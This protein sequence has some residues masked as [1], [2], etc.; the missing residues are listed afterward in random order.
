MKKL[1]PNQKILREGSV[2]EVKVECEKVFK[3]FSKTM[4]SNPKAASYM[5]GNL[6][7]FLLKKKGEE[8]KLVEQCI[9]QTKEKLNKK[10][11]TDLWSGIERLTPEDWKTLPAGNKNSLEALRQ[12]MLQDIH[13]FQNID[14]QSL[15]RTG[16]EFRFTREV[17][18]ALIRKDLLNNKRS[19]PFKMD[20]FD[21]VLLRTGGAEENHTYLYSFINKINVLLINDVVSL[22]SKNEKI[23]EIILKD[24]STTAHYFSVSE[25]LAEFHPKLRKEI[26]ENWKKQIATHPISSD[27]KDPLKQ[28]LDRLKAKYPEF[29]EVEPKGR[30]P[31]IQPRGADDEP[32]PAWQNIAG[33]ATVGGIL[34]F[35]LKATV[36]VCT[37]PALLPLYF[38]AGGA[39]LGLACSMSES[40]NQAEKKM[41][42]KV[43]SV[44][45]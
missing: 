38:I 25:K 41:I 33:G 6:Y 32:I 39:G 8:K 43:K 7:H 18:I 28:T 29:K 16:Q 44:F 12:N 15:I 20:N 11:I 19:D 40:A 17:L 42:Q 26:A 1:Y 37:A 27:Q 10:Q 13:Y 3:T 24:F 36:C 21:Y 2:S 45:K 23:A 4:T 31:R 14:N 30:A 34:Y 35:G 22:G 9:K 5:L